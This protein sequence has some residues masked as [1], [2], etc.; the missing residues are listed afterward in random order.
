MARKTMESILTKQAFS[1][2]G[3]YRLSAKSRN[4]KAPKKES[5]KTTTPP[6]PTSS[7]SPEI[8][9]KKIRGIGIATTLGIVA[10]GFIAGNYIDNIADEETKA[11]ATANSTDN[12]YT[13]IPLQESLPPI[14]NQPTT[15]LETYEVTTTAP[16][17]LVGELALN[18]DLGNGEHIVCTD[19]HN[20]TKLSGEYLLTAIARS[21]EEP[22]LQYMEPSQVDLFIEHIQKDLNGG[23]VLDQSK[24][25]TYNFTSVK[26][27]EGYSTI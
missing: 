5:A 27:C 13:P 22:M 18:I 25:A 7:G 11:T 19:I 26:G 15:S 2:P 21:A 14:S 16:V 4:H 20:T 1:L 8:K 9:F 3:E 23:A 24:Q 17:A 6:D 10:V 12:S